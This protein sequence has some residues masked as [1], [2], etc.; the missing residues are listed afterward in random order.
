MYNL[1]TNQYYFYAYILCWNPKNFHSIFFFKK[2]FNKLL[3]KSMTFEFLASVQIW[4]CSSKIIL[5]RV[6]R[7]CSFL[8]SVSLHSIISA[9]PIDFC[10]FCSVLFKAIVQLSVANNDNVTKLITK[11]N[12]VT[13]TSCLYS[14]VHLI[15]CTFVRA[16][17]LKSWIITSRLKCQ[18]LLTGK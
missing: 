3:I 15:T 16:A 1:N 4:S 6:V 9:L 7:F 17:W 10:S 18:L 8:C 11:D 2:R 12:H 14:V 5:F 13:A